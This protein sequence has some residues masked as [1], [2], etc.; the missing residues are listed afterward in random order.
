MIVIQNDRKCV[1][2]KSVS[3]SR[4]IE[5]IELDEANLLERTTLHFPRTFQHVSGTK[6]VRKR[7]SNQNHGRESTVLASRPATKP[8]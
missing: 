2:S 6:L 8:L 1:L 3:T 7:S 5:K 4:L